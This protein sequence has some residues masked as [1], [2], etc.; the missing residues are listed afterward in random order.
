MKGKKRNTGSEQLS[1]GRGTKELR[2]ITVAWGY[3]ERAAGLNFGCETAVLLRSAADCATGSCWDGAWSCTRR[4]WR[5]T[6]IL[7]ELPAKSKLGIR[8]E[9]AETQP[10]LYGIPNSHRDPRAREQSGPGSRA[11][12]VLHYSRSSPP[13]APPQS[14]GTLPPGT[15]APQ[16]KIC[17]PGGCQSC[18]LWIRDSSDTCCPTS[19]HSSP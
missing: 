19:C 18:I 3:T 11:L 8:A 7:Q 1:H 6:G 12:S 2:W 16:S 15:G 14:P 17:Q 5:D 9:P 10:H 13:C 4:L